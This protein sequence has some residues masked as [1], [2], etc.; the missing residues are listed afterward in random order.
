MRRTVLLLGLLVLPVSCQPLQ[1]DGPTTST[2][3]PT[4]PAGDAARVT[5]VLDGDSVEVEIDGR[6]EEVRLLGINAP[7]EDECYGDRAREGLKGMADGEQVTLVQGSVDDRDEFGRL[8]R[9][10]YTD[11]RSVNEAML[12]HGQAVALQRDHDQNDSFVRI[13]TDAAMRE[14]GLWERDACGPATVQDIRVTW[15]EFNPPGPD[16]EVLEDEYVEIVNEGALRVDLAEWT[17]RDESS[18]NRYVFDRALRPGD[19]MLVRSGCGEDREEDVYWCSGG[20][21]WSN[22]G[23]TAILQDEHGNVVSWRTYRGA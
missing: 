18:Q 17:L 19:R 8:L 13:A 1:E 9:Y 4:T 2:S 23:D 11:D 12:F 14:T 21:I 5:F 3:S 7:E 22:G 20:P 10:V 15:V 16:D 6:N